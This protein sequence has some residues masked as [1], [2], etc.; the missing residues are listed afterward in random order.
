MTSFIDSKLN[1]IY[2]IDE[3]N[4]IITKFIYI[5]LVMKQMF[6]IS[7]DLIEAYKAMTTRNTRPIDTTSESKVDLIGI[8]FVSIVLG[9]VYI[10]EYIQKIVLYNLLVIDMFIKSFKNRLY[11]KYLNVKLYI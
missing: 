5:C 9:I 1:N 3:Y 8:V 6:I 4:T 11:Q 2:P 7:G 10:I